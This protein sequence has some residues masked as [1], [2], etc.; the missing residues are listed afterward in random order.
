MLKEHTTHS[1]ITGLLQEH[2][3][4]AR[5]DR[6]SIFHFPHPM[7]LAPPVLTSMSSPR[8]AMTFLFFF[9]KS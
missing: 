9:A 3:F 8:I 5:S 6:A 2:P 4:H 7:P 1:M